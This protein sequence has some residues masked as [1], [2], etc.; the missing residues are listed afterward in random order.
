MRCLESPVRCHHYGW[1]SNTT[2]PL[3]PRGHKRGPQPSCVS[4][5]PP[6]HP[7]TLSWPG[8]KIRCKP[9]ILLLHDLLNG[10]ILSFKNKWTEIHVLFKMSHVAF[11]IGGC[12]SMIFEKLNT[13]LSYKYIEVH[14]KDWLN[15]LMREWAGWQNWLKGRYQN[16]SV[17]AGQSME[18]RMLEKIGNLDTKCQ[19]AILRWSFSTWEEPFVS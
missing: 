11:C 3:S 13:W 15:S 14:A 12:Q 5:S 7:A 17:C 2:P 16:L 1:R 19:K 9:F 6:L 18:T 4:P 8:R 10:P